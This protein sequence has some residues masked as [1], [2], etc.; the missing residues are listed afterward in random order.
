[1]HERCQGI[2]C[3]DVGMPFGSRAAARRPVDAGI[4]D[5]RVHAANRI[6]LLCN[7]VDPG[8]A[9]K[10]TDCDPG[11]LGCEIGKRRGALGRSCMKGDLM[12]SIEKRPRRRATEPVGASGYKNAS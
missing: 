5:N 2:Y 1:K 8:R 12:A 7:A 4:V 10:V 3:Q 9:A 11:S 6:Y